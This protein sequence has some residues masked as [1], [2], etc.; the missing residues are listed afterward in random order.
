[1]VICFHERFLLRSA[2]AASSAVGVENLR[3]PE[4]VTAAR[5]CADALRRSNRPILSMVAGITHCGSTLRMD[6]TAPSQ[7]V[8]CSVARKTRV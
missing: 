5:A 4:A 3:P 2:A 6:L 1:M 7:H 8:S